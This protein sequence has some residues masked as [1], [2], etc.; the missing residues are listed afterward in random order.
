MN[1]TK[2]NYSALVLNYW[3]RRTSC[4]GFLDLICTLDQGGKK[5]GLNSHT[6]KSHPLP[7]GIPVSLSVYIHLILITARPLS[8]INL[9]VPELLLWY[10]KV[11]QVVW[12][13]C[14][15]LFL[16]F[17]TKNDCWACKGHFIAVHVVRF[18]L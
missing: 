15:T 10:C 5:N 8:L 7:A 2:G 17:P 1:D 14:E 18:S 12:N 9:A 11:I 6:C 13:C 16:D 3:I 4:T